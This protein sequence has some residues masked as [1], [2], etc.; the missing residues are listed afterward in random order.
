[1]G[2]KPTK[3]LNLPPKMRVENR[4]VGKAYYLDTNKIVDGKMKRCW[5]LLGH[6]FTTALQNYAETVGAN[7]KEK[8]FFTFSDAWNKYQLTVLIKKAPQTQ[9]GNLSESKRLL[10]T[11]GKAM[12][13]EIKPMH[14]RRYLDHYSDKPRQADKEMALFSHVF[15]CARAWGL[16]EAANPVA[17]IEKHNSHGRKVY[18]YDEILKKVYDCA[19]V[20]LR[21]FM[22]FMYLS[23]QRNMDSLKADERHIIDGCYEF[24]Q[25]KTGKHMRIEVVGEFGALIDRIRKRKM[26][27][28]IVSTRLLVD[29]DGTPMTKDK[30][31]SRFDTARKKAGVPK[32]D[33]QLRDLRAK[34]ITDK[35][36]S[37]S[38]AEASAQGGHSDASFTQRTYV[39]RGKK[40]QP[41]K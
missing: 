23:G 18:I 15:N 34:A 5:V 27:N 25:G 1:M 19:D 35:T 41:T 17:G 21:D 6:D 24:S 26:L 29:L 31:R 3:N 36:D 12:L 30:I 16:T 33:F 11:F 4:K 28:K 32:A 2:R 20:P 22:D 14:I 13:D 37:H 40:V 8:T 7:E 9:R 10:F 38:L 39:R